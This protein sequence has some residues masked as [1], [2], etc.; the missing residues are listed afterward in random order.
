[1]MTQPTLPAEP[2]LPRPYSNSA[3]HRDFWSREKELVIVDLLA[4]VLHMYP[5]LI[6]PVPWA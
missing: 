5:W 6:R 4:S 2:T 1:M 3:F